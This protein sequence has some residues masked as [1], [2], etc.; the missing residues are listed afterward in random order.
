MC[1]RAGAPVALSSDAHRPQDVGADYAQALALLA[2]VG[3]REL[4]VF[5]HRERRLAPI[6]ADAPLQGQGAT[7]RRRAMS[8]I[9]IGYDSHRLAAGSAAGDRR[10]RDRG[11][12][13]G[14]KGTPTPTCWRT[15]SS[16]RCS[17]RPAWATSASS[18]PTATSA[19]A[20]PTRSTLLAQVVA[21]VADGGFQI[22]NVDCTVVMEAPRLTRAQGGDPRAPGEGARG[23]ARAR[24]RQGQQRRGHRLRRAR[25]GRRGDG[26]RQP[27][28]ARLTRGARR[29]TARV[30]AP[31]QRSVCTTRAAAS[32][33][34]WFPAIAAAWASTPAGRPSTAAS[35]SATR[36]RLSS[37]ACS[38]A[39]WS[40]PAMR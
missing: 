22:V 33:W 25:R 5:E 24:E 21:N 16:T 23:L 26:G 19:T 38:S 1:V 35:T 11:R 10:R 31:W 6:G 20:T 12:A 40:T 37:S 7:G 36:G 28:R 29:A 2:R 32:R 14:S 9:G 34:R 13:W 27:A 30:G 18:S 4:C 8:P 17:A 15:R 3:V 39:S